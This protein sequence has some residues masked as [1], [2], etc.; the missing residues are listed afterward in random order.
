MKKH[1]FGLTAML[2]LSAFQSYDMYVMGS[3]SF[4]TN[5]T[6]VLNTNYTFNEVHGEDYRNGMWKLRHDTLIIQEGLSHHSKVGYTYPY[7]SFF[8]VKTGGILIGTDLY[9]KVP[10]AKPESSGNKK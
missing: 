3:Y 2:T 4:G 8:L 1:F 7:R 9:K 6:L 10:P 5:S